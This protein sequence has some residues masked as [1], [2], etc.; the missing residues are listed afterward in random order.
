[1]SARGFDFRLPWPFNREGDLFS[2]DQEGATWLPNGNPFDELLHI[3]GR[4]PLRI[5][6]KTPQ[7]LAGVSIDETER[8]RLHAT[9]INPLVGLKFQ[10]TGQ[11]WTN[12]RSILVAR[13]RDCLRLF[14]RQDFG[15]RKLVKSAAGYVAESQLIASLPVLSVDACVSP[16]G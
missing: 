4:S 11:R 10:R 6:T 5:P 8:I 7:T 14:P 3:Q 15:A 2:T 12:L 13:R 1:L 9:N 16:Q